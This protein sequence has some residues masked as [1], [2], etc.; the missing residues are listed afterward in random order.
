MIKKLSNSVREYKKE[1]IKTSFFVIIEI[2]LD[3]LIPIVMGLLVD[4][5]INY[6]NM[7]NIVLYGFILV[8]CAVIALYFGYLSGKSASIASSG[9]AKNLRNDIFKKVSDFS[10]SNIDKFSTSSLITR[11]TTDTTNVQNAF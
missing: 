3:V 7:N 2:I 5:G 4:K 6:G 9:F 10:F 8:I 11:I 1:A